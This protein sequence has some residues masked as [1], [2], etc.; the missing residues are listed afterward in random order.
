MREMAQYLQRKGYEPTEVETT[1]EYLQSLGYLTGPVE[2]PRTLD[3]KLL[4]AEYLITLKGP[5]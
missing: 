4:T 2:R 3:G 5:S 1:Q